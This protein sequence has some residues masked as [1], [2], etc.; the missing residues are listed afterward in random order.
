MMWQSGK[1]GVVVFLSHCAESWYVGDTWLL[2]KQCTAAPCWP[3]AEHIIWFIFLISFHQMVFRWNASE[4]V[5]GVFCQKWFRSFGVFFGGF[6]L[7]RS[8]RVMWLVARVWLRRVT[9]QTHLLSK[10]GLREA[11]VFLHV[12]VQFEKTGA[13]SV[14]LHVTSVFLCLSQLV[15][16]EHRVQRKRPEPG[17]TLTFIL[18]LA[19]EYGAGPRMVRRV[20]LHV[21]LC[22]NTKHK[23]TQRSQTHSRSP[24]M[25]LSCK[26]HIVH[27][28]LVKRSLHGTNSHNGDDSAVSS[29]VLNWLYSK[30]LHSE[31]ISIK[32]SDD[33]TMLRSLLASCFIRWT[34]CSKDF[35]S[36][37][38]C[39]MFV[40]C[41]SAPEATRH[42][43]TCAMS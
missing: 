43:H 5:F 12:S 31:W 25:Y 35:L 29:A 26:T 8:L 27:C 28:F 21:Q 6:E 23:Q 42:W 33:V 34:R 17:E 10:W 24:L 32:W 1:L 7:S 18:G 30:T 3:A 15:S 11:S 41:S 4:F 38:H 37:G 19:E 36:K 39:S 20:V 14:S 16:C 13:R 9:C 2:V 22:H 40:Y